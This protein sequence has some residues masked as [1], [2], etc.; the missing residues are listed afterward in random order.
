[1]TK[2]CL[3]LRETLG[4]LRAIA[5]V[6]RRCVVLRC[7]D[8]PRTDGDLFAIYRMRSANTS[9]MSTWMYLSK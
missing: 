8:P 5:D 4:G 7:G 9:S 2:D 3:T 1:M 6:H